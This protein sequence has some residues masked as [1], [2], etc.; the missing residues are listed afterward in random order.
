MRTVT[1]RTERVVIV[2]AGLGGLAAAIRLAA[3][4]R[5][6]TIL[7]RE[8][9]PGGRAGRLSPDGDEVDTGPTVLTMPG[10]L[11]GLGGSGRENLHDRRPPKPPDPAHPA[12]LPDGAH[13]GGTTAPPP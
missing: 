12:H 6:V 11:A 13:R 1:G 4:G 7:E 3:A 2:G 10:L 8:S 5:E 9:V